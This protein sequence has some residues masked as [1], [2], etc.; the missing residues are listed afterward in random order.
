MKHI[1][2]PLLTGL[3]ATACQP[4]NDFT[5]NGTLAEPFTG[6]V[7]LTCIKDRLTKVDSLT[8]NGGTTFKFTGTM[9]RPDYYRIMTS[10]RTYDASLIIEPGS[11]YHM[12]ILD[13]HD[14]QVEVVRGG[15]E[16]LLLNEYE[17]LMMPIRETDQR[18]GDAYAQIE[19]SDKQ[20]T[21]S[22]QKLMSDNFLAR[23][24]RC[25]WL[26][27]IDSDMTLH[28]GKLIDNY[29]NTE[30]EGA[31]YG[32]YEIRGDETLLRG[33]LRYKYE[34]SASR[35]NS[36][37]ERHRSQYDKFH[38][39]NFAIRRAVMLDHPLDE[40]ITRY[41]H[42]DLLFGKTLELSGIRITHIDN[43]VTF[44]DFE[45]NA[46]F[47]A[48]T[49]E[50]VAMLCELENEL[51]DFSNIIKLTE[52]LERLRLTPAVR[53]FYKIFS[54][55]LKSNLTG[56]KPSVLLFNIYKLGMFCTIKYRKTRPK[57]SHPDA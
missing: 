38:I 52:R 15:K 43:P 41:G 55:R 7:Y 42:E 2:Y 16:Q 19:R 18:L 54:N 32:G 39:S 50:S 30:T 53:L 9:E 23:E 57:T 3:L 56:N 49:E 34:K 51:R 12:N 8:L 10:P 35:N 25:E 14:C 48:K 27:F 26:L 24:A 11:E 40:R 36:A 4:G 1:I 37:T 31:I 33:N 45:T 20:K 28:N 46:D 6:Q 22:L 47:M 44:E 29:I 13:T 17:Q 21:D 5:V